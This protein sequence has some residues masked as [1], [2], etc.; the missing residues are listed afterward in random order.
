MNPMCTIQVICIIM[1]MLTAEVG[2]VLL[3]MLGLE[4]VWSHEIE[5]YQHSGVGSCC[6]RTR[7]GGDDS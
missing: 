1:T 2:V 7:E 5:A 4:I 6:Q 3:S